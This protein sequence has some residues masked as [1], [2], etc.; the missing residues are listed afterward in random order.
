MAKTV[1]GATDRQII[2]GLV[3]AIGLHPAIKNPPVFYPVLREGQSPQQVF[4]SKLRT[5]GG[6]ELIDPGLTIAVYPMFSS[7]DSSGDNPSS[8]SGSQ[9]AGYQQHTL[10]RP[11]NFSYFDRG[12]LRFVVQIYYRDPNFNVSQ[13]VTYGKKDIDSLS[14]LFN[15]YGE[16]F[17]TPIDG[18]DK[19]SDKWEFGTETLDLTISP[20]EEVIRDYTYLVRSVLREIGTLKPFGIKQINVEAVDYPSSSWLKN[21]QNIVF[22]TS[23]ITLS[24]SVYETVHAKD[25][26]YLAPGWAEEVNQSQ[27]TNPYKIST[28]ATEFKDHL[29]SLS[30]LPGNWS[31]VSN[32]NR[33]DEPFDKS[34]P[35]PS[36]DPNLY[37]GSEPQSK[38]EPTLDE[39]PTTPYS[40]S[41][42]KVSG[43][44]NIRVDNTH[45]SPY[46]IDYFPNQERIVDPIVVKGKSI[47]ELNLTHD[48]NDK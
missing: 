38:P 33:F 41:T 40:P 11:D 48:N 28:V 6:L 44:T 22:H 9:F 5:F 7:Y 18:K 10:G 13:S 29:N 4:V 14:D 23:Y 16:S 37:L 25:P 42:S 45:Y 27:E 1:R 24:I 39:D 26:N 35:L 19:V 34:Y 3:G 17:S 12:E 46:N 30:M 8:S 2:L 36:F 15:T 43:I 31:D 21:S 47:A 20:G 32:P